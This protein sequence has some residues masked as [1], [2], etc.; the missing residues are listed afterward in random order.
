MRILAISGEPG[1]SPAESRAALAKMTAQGGKLETKI[2][3]DDNE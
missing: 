3:T 1:D 2:E